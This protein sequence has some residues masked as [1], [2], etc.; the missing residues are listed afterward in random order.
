M[1]GMSAVAVRLLASEE[2]IG[3]MA[4]TGFFNDTVG[5]YTAPRLKSG[6]KET[7]VT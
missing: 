3:W 7:V 4:F 2:G 1:L 5:A 6:R